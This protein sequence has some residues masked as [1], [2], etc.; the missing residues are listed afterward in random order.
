MQ[1]PNSIL[2][3]FND[4]LEAKWWTLNT[5]TGESPSQNTNKAIQAITCTE[6]KLLQKNLELLETDII[7]G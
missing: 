1:G 7:R 2:W 3:E 6:K 5:T 4:S